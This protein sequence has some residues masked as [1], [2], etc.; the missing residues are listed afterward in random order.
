MHKATVWRVG[1]TALIV[2]MVLRL[3]MAIADHHR[4]EHDLRIWWHCVK[5]VDT[6]PP[7][8][9]I[10]VSMSSDSMNAQ[11]FGAWMQ[12]IGTAMLRYGL[13]VI[14]LM[15]GATKW[16]PTEAEAIRPWV[17]HSPFLSWIY[18]V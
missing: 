1:G 13:V 18:R 16:T 15:I 12:N 7:R 9:L 4:S 17:A 11:R 2:V 3:E 14:L 5:H 10:G 6:R 8:P